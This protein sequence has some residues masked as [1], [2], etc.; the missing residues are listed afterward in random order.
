MTNANPLITLRN[1]A[2]I[3]IGCAVACFVGTWW[4]YHFLSDAGQKVMADIEKS[5]VNMTLLQDE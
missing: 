5:T 1:T 3:W 2:I 4:L